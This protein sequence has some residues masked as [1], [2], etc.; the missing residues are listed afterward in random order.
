MRIRHQI[1]ECSLKLK[2]AFAKKLNFITVNM[3]LKKALIFYVL[4][5]G[6]ISY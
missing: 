2:R 1:L 4:F 5:F 3:D 6:A